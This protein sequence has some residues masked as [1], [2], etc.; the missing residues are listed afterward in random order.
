MTTISCG[1]IAQFCTH[2]NNVRFPQDVEKL[3]SPQGFLE[4]IVDFFTRGGVSKKYEEQYN[5]FHDEMV[6]AINKRNRNSSPPDNMEFSFNKFTIE[7]NFPPKE[8]N[9]KDIA[10]K[11]TENKGGYC[12]GEIEMSQ[13]LNKLP[14]ILLSS[15]IKNESGQSVQFFLTAG[16]KIDLGRVGAP[17]NVLKNINFKGIDLGYIHFVGATLKNAKLE[18]TDVKRAFHNPNDFFPLNHYN[19]LSSDFSGSNFSGSDFLNSNFSGSDL[20]NSKFK[21]TKFS[22]TNLSFTNLKNADLTDVIL[23]NVN[24]I[25]ADLQGAKLGDLYSKNNNSK[26][27]KLPAEW[28]KNTVTTYLDHLNN[29]KKLSL[30]TAI[31][32]ID[33]EYSIQKIQLATEIIKSLGEN[34][35]LAALPLIEAFYQSPYLDDKALR[36]TLNSII[37]AYLTKHKD[38]AL[39]LSS[40]TVSKALND[41]FENTPAMKET[42]PTQWNELTR[43]RDL[44]RIL[45]GI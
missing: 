16:G 9:G 38:S 20:S 42:F 29:S 27:L 13:Y 24:I 5:D 36:I 32:S 23:H 21:L 22:F 28:N 1:R 41:Y 3:F 30:L 19:F 25:G 43:K 45:P 11:V 8:S 18:G 40:Q 17:G 44:D 2:I 10:I 12:N 7:F 39:D 6:K 26:I 15:Q 31:N 35:S 33:N 14:G 4:H 37:D 34:I